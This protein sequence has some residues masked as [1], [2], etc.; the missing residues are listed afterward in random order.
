MKPNRC[1]NI[2]VSDEIT[3]MTEVC[4][5]DKGVGSTIIRAYAFFISLVVFLS[6][7]LGGCEYDDVSGISTRTP[8]GD[9]PASP[10]WVTV[11]FTDPDS[12]TARTYRGG[13]DK[14]LAQAIDQA[15]L[16]VDV[17]IYDLSLIHI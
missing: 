6:L 5:R 14:F 11:Y 13:P 9:M 1:Y 17:A 7:C 15:R 16:S 4:P 10:D 8:I 12:P 2:T 3:T